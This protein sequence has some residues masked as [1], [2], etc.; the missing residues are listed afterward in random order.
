MKKV[1]YSADQDLSRIESL[2]ELKEMALACCRCGLRPECSGVVFGE[3][4]PGARLLL[5]GEGP[6]AEEDR[7]G[8]PFAGKAGQL[9]DQILGAIGLDR[10]EHTYIANVVKCRPPNNRVPRPEEARQCLPWLYRQIELISPAL[11]VL[12]GGTALQNLVDPDARITRMRG[13]WLESRSGIKIMPT[14]HPA[15]LLRDPGKKRPVWE[16]FQKVRDEYNSIINK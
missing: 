16:D 7:L 8:R 3:G 14:Y 12:L 13:Q 10:F 6:G 2:D 1:P 11:I 15:A 9:L 4:N 5:I